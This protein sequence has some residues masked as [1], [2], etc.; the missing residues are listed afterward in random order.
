MM[1]MEEEEEEE[2]KPPM[3]NFGMGMGVVVVGFI[4]ASLS[5]SLSSLFLLCV[6]NPHSN[7]VLSWRAGHSCK[8]PVLVSRYQ[9]I[10]N[11]WQ[12]ERERFGFHEE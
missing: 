10:S 9:N 7:L 2:E 1:T 11:L 6:C 8:P 3:V 4:S 5:L 12:Q